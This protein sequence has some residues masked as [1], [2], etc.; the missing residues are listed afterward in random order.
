MV[1]TTKKV[2]KPVDWRAIIL[3]AT[4]RAIAMATVAEQAGVPV[5]SVKIFAAPGQRADVDV[6]L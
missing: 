2:S 6:R 1:T 5:K 4:D 3:E